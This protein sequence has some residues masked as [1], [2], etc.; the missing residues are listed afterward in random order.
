MIENVR[1][2]NSFELLMGD[3]EIAD[4]A[5]DIGFANGQ[6]FRRAFKRR[7]NILPSAFRQLFKKSE[8]NKEEKL[9]NFEKYL[10]NDK[11]NR[12]LSGEIAP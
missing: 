5:L 2:E 6:S 12:F 3:D 10:W 7:L 11:K 9:K 8:E 1:L 4:I